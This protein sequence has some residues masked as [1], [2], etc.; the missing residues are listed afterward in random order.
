MS[1]RRSVR[2]TAVLRP[3]DE[4]DGGELA[5]RII[6][7]LAGADLGVDV[8]SVEE[9]GAHDPLGFDDVPLWPELGR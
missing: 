4:L 7:A 8:S 1:D 2:L 3:P 5:D 9:L 6:A